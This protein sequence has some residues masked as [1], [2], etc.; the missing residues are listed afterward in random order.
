VS[1]INDRYGGKLTE[2]RVDYQISCSY[3]FELSFPHNVSN[4]RPYP[5]RMSTPL[6]YS[7]IYFVSIAEEL[8]ISK[9]VAIILDDMRFL[10]TSVV[11]QVDRTLSDEEISKLWTTSMWI[12]DRISAMPDGNDP[13]SH[14]TTDYIYKACRIAALLYCK[15]I[16]QRTPLSRVCTMQDLNQL[17]ANMWRVTLTRWKQ[18]PGVFL[19]ILFSA[20][21]AAQE[22]PHGRFLKSMLKATSSYLALDYWDI[23]D[24]ASMAYV[25]LQR[26]LRR[27][28]AGMGAVGVGMGVA[29]PERDMS[30]LHNYKR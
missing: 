4:S 1:S 22:T 14:L 27:E 30:F 5:P 7:Q 29:K 10:T 19:W 28:A 13:A 6:L 24:G 2:I 23:V 26:W 3:D 18:T 15:A 20:N 8:Q 25:K 21:P 11:R 12:Q 17:W 9:E 16:V